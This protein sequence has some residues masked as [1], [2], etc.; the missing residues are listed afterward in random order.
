ME[1]LAVQATRI[2]YGR[3]Q[4]IFEEEEPSS[5]PAVDKKQATKSTKVHTHFLRCI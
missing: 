2:D 5:S 1:S 3:L 4:T